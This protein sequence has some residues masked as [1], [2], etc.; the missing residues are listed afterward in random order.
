MKKQLYYSV[1]E[2]AKMI[3]KTR[4]EIVRRIWKGDIKAKKIAGRYLIHYTQLKGIK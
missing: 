2:I 3:N 4:Q 1:S